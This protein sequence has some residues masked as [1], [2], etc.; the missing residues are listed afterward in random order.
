M[1]VQTQGS[2]RPIFY[3]HV[4]WIGGAFYSFTLA[5]HL[6]PD[7]PLYIIDPYRFDGLQVPPTIET[8]AASYIK[9]MRDVQPEGPYFLAGFCAGGLIAYEIAQQLRVQG[10]AVDLLVLIDP[11][12]G[13]IRIHQVTWRF[14]PSHWQPD[15]TQPRK[16][17]RL[18]SAPSLCC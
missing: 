8:M 6:G 15:T 9:T 7:Q 10:Q 5:H 1:P 14:H 18:V 3:L 11:M 12:A 4:H 2:K 13:P 17:V 16:T